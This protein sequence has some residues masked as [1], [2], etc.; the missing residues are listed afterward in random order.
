MQLQLVFVFSAHL[1]IRFKILFESILAFAF[2]GYL[3]SNH[4]S[5]WV[6]LLQTILELYYFVMWSNNYQL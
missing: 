6:N 3:L 2:F 5:Q 1:L 4:A